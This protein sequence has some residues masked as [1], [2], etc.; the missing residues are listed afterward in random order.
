MCGLAAQ[1]QFDAT[2]SSEVMYR[3]TMHDLQVAS[4]TGD[5]PPRVLIDGPSGSGKSVALAAQVARVR[6]A[7][8]VVLYVPSAFALTQDAFFSRCRGNAAQLAVF[9]LKL[10][11]QTSRQARSMMT[12][13]QAVA[14][15]CAQSPAASSNQMLIQHQAFRY[16][17][18][19]RCGS[20]PADNGI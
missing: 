1:S 17:I 11:A 10:R 19:V 20:G 8:T 5:A 12:C 9:V 15:L 14:E 7:G 3:E 16:V 4:S 18:S 13:T 6:A 2:G